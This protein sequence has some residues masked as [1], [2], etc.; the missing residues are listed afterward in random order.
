MTSTGLAHDVMAG[1][2]LVRL[3]PCRQPTPVAVHLCEA[4]WPSNTDGHWTQALSPG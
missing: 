4:A 3:P 1:M 2:L